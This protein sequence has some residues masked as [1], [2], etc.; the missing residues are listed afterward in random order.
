MSEKTYVIT[1]V[2]RLS[3]P[4]LFTP[5][6]F[7][8]KGKEQYSTVILIDKNDTETVN[9][10]KTA[11]DV[12]I[13]EGIHKRFNGRRP[14][15]NSLLIPLKDGDIGKAKLDEAYENMYYINATTSTKPQVVDQNL[16][17]IVE[18]SMIKGGDYAH[19]SLSFYAYN[20]GMTK[21]VKCKLG[22][23]QFVKSGEKLG[24]YTRSAAKDFSKID[25]DIL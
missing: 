7:E 21:G 13:E 14:A 20:T 10:I 23:V 15:E 17:D 19:V 18:P 4:H 1:G 25:D 3:Y 11:I 2:V 12:A 5:Y 9:A 24:S 6:S 8:N 16:N 22:N